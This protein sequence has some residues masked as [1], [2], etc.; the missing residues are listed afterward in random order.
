M[1]VLKAAFIKIDGLEKVIIYHRGAET[2]R[3]AN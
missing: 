2:Q 1:C 3:N